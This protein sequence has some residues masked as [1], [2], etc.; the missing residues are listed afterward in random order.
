M[1]RKVLAVGVVVPALVII[2]STGPAP[3]SAQRTC[4]GL[5]ATIVGTVGDDR[6]SGTRGADV[7]VGRGGNDELFGLSGDDVLC[8]G[9]G[10][11]DLVGGR[12]HDQLYGGL[13]QRE[14]R[15]RR[16]VVSGDLL[17]GGPGDDRL[18]AGFDDVEGRRLV[19]R[20]N[21]VSFLHSTRAVTVNLQDGVAVGEGSDVV[22]RGSLLEVNGSRHDDVLHGSGQAE[23][24]DGGRGDDQVFGGGGRD[25]VLGYHGSDQL[26][27]EQGKDLVI[28]TAGASTVDGGD[29]A[30]WL[31]AAGPAPTT[32]LGGAGFDYMERWITAGETGV[33][34][35]G[36]DAD[37][38]ELV[39]QLWFDRDPSPTLDAEAG[40]AVVTAGADTHTTAF[41]SVDSF[42]LWGSPW[43]FS[44]TEARDFVQVLDGRLDAQGLGGDDYLV[45]AQRH[46]VLDGGDGT[47]TVWGG[48]GQNTCLNAESGSCTG[49]PWDAG[50][51]RARGIVSSPPGL[52]TTPPHRLVSRWTNHEDL[53]RTR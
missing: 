7:V 51:M 2:A 8:G 35:G 45:G 23:A 32:L 21:I 11:D 36:A 39:N 17:E 14:E 1:V 3:A 6:L 48:K 47:D 44:G 31:A 12:G 16:T 9:P 13:D 26:L 18:S 33:I 20:R 38:L 42:T 40:T 34:D 25:A 43:T 49:Y 30:D 52:S 5:A 4:R 27:G 24:L 10:A 50:S 15:G 41:T 53:L 37:H 19:R 46:D 22:V 28:S 29:G